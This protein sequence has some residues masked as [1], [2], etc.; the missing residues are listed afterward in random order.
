MPHF[1]KFGK[2]YINL[3]NV[4][5]VIDREDGIFS[6]RYIVGDAVSY[7]VLASEMEEFHKYLEVQSNPLR[8]FETIKL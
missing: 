8:V 5:S 4:R 2:N 3:D 6:L 7:E 1:V